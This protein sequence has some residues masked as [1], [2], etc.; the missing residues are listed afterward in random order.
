M[1]HIPRARAG[2]VPVQP[3]LFDG[4]PGG[5]ATGLFLLHPCAALPRRRSAEGAQVRGARPTT[6][7]PTCFLF[8]GGERS[9]PEEVN[10]RRR[11]QAWQALCTNR[12]P[13]RASSRPARAGGRFQI[14]RRRPGSMCAASPARRRPQEPILNPRWPARIAGP[15]RI[16]ER[17]PGPHHQHAE[18]QPS[19][20]GR[21]RPGGRRGAALAQGN[22]RPLFRPD[23]SDQRGPSARSE[24][25]RSLDAA[26]RIV[27]AVS[28]PQPWPSGA[29]AGASSSTVLIDDKSYEGSGPFL[30]W[31]AILDRFFWRI[32]QPQTI[33]PRDR[34]PHDR[35]R[36]DSCVG[37]RRLG[38]AERVMSYARTSSS[39]K[40]L[41]L[42]S[43]Q[44]ACAG[45]EREHP[46]KKPRVRRPGDASADEYV[47]LS[48]DPIWNSPPST[49]EGAVREESG[50]HSPESRRFPSAMF[51]PAKGALPLT[52]DRGGLIA[53]CSERERRLSPASATSFQRAP[54]LALFVLSRPGPIR[55]RSP[56]ERTARARDPLHHLYRAR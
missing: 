38:L 50:A 5:A 36:R 2:R 14:P 23:M 48:Q 55:V 32:C 31:A 4:P 42:R 46:A 28:P 16:G 37:R 8:A 52:T 40:T 51:G 43:P 12:P 47:I 1:R 15:R 11:A 56:Q 27:R 30:M 49:L 21:A 33:S 17:P 20:A 24:G 29:G 7:A 53:G 45:F 41:A 26:P 9:D 35:T 39:S 10:P 22:A 3:L 19:R 13:A 25:L 34:D 44:H 54:A 18:P 6:P